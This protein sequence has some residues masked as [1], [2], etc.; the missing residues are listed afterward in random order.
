MGKNKPLEDLIFE[1]KEPVHIPRRYDWKIPVFMT[2]LER[3]KHLSTDAN[4]GCFYSKEFRGEDRPNDT[5]DTQKLYESG[6]R[7]IDILSVRAI[8]GD[9]ESA[10]RLALL[11]L[12]STK[13]LTA[14]GE[15][16]PELLQ[17]LAQRGREWP[18][19]KE[20]RAELSLAEEKLFDAIQL[21]KCDH[22]ELDGK[23]AKW[24][25]DAAALKAIEWLSLIHI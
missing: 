17:S 3:L 1:S 12:E 6:R 16:K 19:I 8:T 4:A 9:A 23:S 22:L 7:V 25:W 11:A 2:T 18:V 13:M 20:R 24:I 15:A 21:G 10:H 5:W 14:I